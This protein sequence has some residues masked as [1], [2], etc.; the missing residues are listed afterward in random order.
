[1]R[2]KRLVDAQ[3][4]YRWHVR[5]L[6]LGHT[7]DIG[8]G[9]GRNLLHLRGQGVGVD[10]NQTSVGVCR[11]RGLVAYTADEFLAAPHAVPGA[12]DSIL[13][14]HVL[15]HLPASTADT[16]LRTYLPFLRP[17]GQVVLI[18]PQERGFA[19]DPTHVRFVDFG[20]ASALTAAL[21]LRVQRQYSF[22][23][24]RVAGRLFAYNEF[25]TVARAPRS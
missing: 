11:C 24:P 10:T 9:L 2:W 19:S 5:Q 14:A 6:R 15:E 18:T 7:L 21:G 16:L 1:M 12:F 23:F 17:G 8:C 13:V 3:A 25:V 22:P 4:P 20:A